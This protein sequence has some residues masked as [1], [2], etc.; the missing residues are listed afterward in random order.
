MIS[1]LD[2]LDNRLIQELKTNARMTYTTLSKK[3]GVRP[4]TVRRR[5]Q[6]LVEDKVVSFEALPNPRKLGYCVTAFMGFRA[7]LAMSTQVAARL[8]AN[9]AFIY[10]STTSGFYDLFGW[11]LFRSPEHVAEFMVRDISPIEGIEW[12]ET[13]VVLRH[14]KVDKVI[15]HNSSTRECDA[16]DSLIIRALRGDVRAPYATLSARLGLSIP[17]VRQR[18]EQMSR[19]GDMFFVPWVDRTKMGFQGDTTIGIRTNLASLAEVQR[20]LEANE[21]VRMLAMVTGRFDFLVWTCFLDSE[22][23]TRFIQEDLSSM[24]GIEHYDV[25]FH[26]DVLKRSFASAIGLI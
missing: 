11:A 21:K 25:F 13:L 17:T 1:S 24:R 22:Q 9:P 3:L 15:T 6:R 23:L 5:L 16:L 8:A 18:V 14:C 10:L 20:Q 12:S 2:T 26:L 4:V 19:E 7:K